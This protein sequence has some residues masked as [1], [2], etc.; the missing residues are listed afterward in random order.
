MANKIFVSYKYSDN[1]VKPLSNLSGLYSQTTARNYVDFLENKLEGKH[2]YKGEQDGED[3]SSF[4]DETIESHLRNKIFD[5]SVTI[6]LI[7][8]GMQELNMPEKD[9]WIPWEISYS[10]RRKNKDD[11]VSVAN[12]MLA[13]V[14]PDENGSYSYFVEH[15]ACPHCNSTSW[16]TRNLFSILHKNMFN[17]KTPNKQACNGPQ[18]DSNYHI[19]DDHSYIHPV[20]WDNFLLNI[21]RYRAMDENISDYLSMV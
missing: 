13:V 12:G 18:C 20:K 14:L 21:D 6:I 5:S 11:R 19:G 3:L 8:K 4:Q 15:S 10:L 2:I 7:S 9:Q 16:K 1:S 17:K